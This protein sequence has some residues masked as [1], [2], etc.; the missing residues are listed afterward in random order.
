MFVISRYYFT[1]FLGW[2]LFLQLEK[3]RDTETLF[4]FTTHSYFTEEKM[5]GN[6]FA[7][8]LEKSEASN[9]TSGTSPIGSTVVKKCIY[10]PVYVGNNRLFL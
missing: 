9:S 10:Q 8:W 3:E 6:S 4:H 2:K 1:C 7:T 5:K